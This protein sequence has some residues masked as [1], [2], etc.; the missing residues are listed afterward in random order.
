ML[1]NAPFINI[2]VISCRSEFLLEETGVSRETTDLPQVT[3]KLYLI[4][5]S[6]VHLTISGIRTH[7]CLILSFRMG[8]VMAVIVW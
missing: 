4:M 2:T 8:V 6:P 1:F 3:D 5:M 7:H